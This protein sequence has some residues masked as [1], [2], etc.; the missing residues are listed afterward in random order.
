MILSPMR[1]KDYCW[2][3]NPT[4]CSITCK[5]KVAALKVPCGRF[6]TQDLGAEYRVMRGEGEFSGE[7]AYKAF[8][9]LVRV[10]E[11][12]GPGLLVHPVWPAAQAHFV[13][14]LLTQEPL[15]DYVRYSFEF[16]EAA[17]GETGV[18]AVQVPT[19]TGMTAQ[20]PQTPAVWHTVKKGDTLWEIARHYGVTLQSLIA[21]N[22]QIKN[23]NLIYPGNQVKVT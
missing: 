4:T 5:R 10:F 17:A 2:P 8:R 7:G 21:N 12:P 6:Y 19:D 13:S 9:E 11:D 22:P 1:Y 18:T 14:L 15:P 16:R 3:H 20:A 23:P